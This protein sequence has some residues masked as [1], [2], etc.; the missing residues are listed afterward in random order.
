MKKVLGMAS[1]IAIGLFH[2]EADAGFYIDM[3]G[4]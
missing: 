1:I 4:V 3:Q 2:F